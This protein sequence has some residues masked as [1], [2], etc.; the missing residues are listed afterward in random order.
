MRLSSAQFDLVMANR[1]KSVKKNNKT[2]RK[3]LNVLEGPECSEC[4]EWSTIIFSKL[5]FGKTIFIRQMLP[6]LRCKDL[7]HACN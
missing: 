1:K 5:K 2:A 7:S 4:S 6:N 3:A